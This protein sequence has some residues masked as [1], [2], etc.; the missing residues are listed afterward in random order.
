M[1]ADVDFTLMDQTCPVVGI[2]WLRQKQLTG[3]KGRK[4]GCEDVYVYTFTA[5]HLKDEDQ[6]YDNGRDSYVFET[7]EH[8]VRRSCDNCNNCDRAAPAFTVGEEPKCWRPTVP[9]MSSEEGTISKWY[10]CGNDWCVKILP[11]QDD[12]ER[13]N[14]FASGLTIAGIVCLSAFLP[15][16]LLAYFI[17]KWCFTKKNP[18]FEN[19][20]TTY[21]P[22]PQHQVAQTTS[23]SYAPDVKEQYNTGTINGNTGG[24]TSLFDQMNSRV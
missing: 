9:D 2:D 11:P 5:N 24:D 15:L 10:R 6:F 22:P 1:D 7:Y 23:S 12:E 14:A 17:V 16:L 21:P 18:T 19:T 3:D 13:A 4:T 20:T 8:Y